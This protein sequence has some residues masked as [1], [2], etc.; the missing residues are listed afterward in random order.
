MFL[1]YVFFFFFGHEA[2]GIKPEPPAL[3][4]EVLT[5]GPL[6]KPLNLIFMCIL[7]RSSIAP[8][9]G[10][11]PSSLP[12]AFLSYCPGI[13]GPRCPWSLMCGSPCLS[14]WCVLPSQ[15]PRGRGAGG[16]AHRWVSPVAVGWL[17]RT[18]G[19]ESLGSPQT[20]HKE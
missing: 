14:L 1:F 20:R 17:F 15:C 13:F 2:C 7:F 3:E 16:E 8:A 18:R 10:V 12:V 19:A 9:I 11:S 5:P 6:G 4:G